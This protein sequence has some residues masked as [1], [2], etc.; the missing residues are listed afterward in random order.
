MKKSTLFI[1]IFLIAA[2][3]AVA[4]FFRPAQVEE[5][6]TGGPSSGLLVGSNAVYA[7][8]QKPGDAVSISMAVLQTAGYVVIHEDNNGAP[9]AILGAS[10]ILEQGQSEGVSVFLSRASQDGEA[11][12]AMLHV[13]NGDGAFDPAQDGSVKDDQGNII[14]MRFNISSTAEESG[15]V[16]L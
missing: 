6:Q 3:G 2:I 14:L 8:D 12:H 10:A 16:S 13:D 15:P 5:E 7:A 11:L 9:G 1:L 4:L